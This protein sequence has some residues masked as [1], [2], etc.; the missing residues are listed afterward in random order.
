MLLFRVVMARHEVKGVLA[1]LT[2]DK[3]LTTSL[4]ARLRPDK[5]IHERDPTDGWGRALWPDAPKGWRRQWVLRKG[6]DGR[7]PKR[8][9]KGGIAFTVGTS[10]RRSGVR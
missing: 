8:A 9:T 2:G 4:E 5:T 3:W 1:N 6:T 7:A 10:G